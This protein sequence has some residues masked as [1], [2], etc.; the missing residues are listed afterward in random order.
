LTAYLF[1]IGAGETA[2]IK[3]HQPGQLSGYRERHQAALLQCFAQHPAAFNP[4]F[5]RCFKARA[6][7]GEDFQ[8]KKMQLVE[9]HSS[10]FFSDA[11]MLRFAA[12]T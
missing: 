9:F 10:R 1:G 2:I 12:D 7:T 3:C 6:E 11:S 8:F 5:H 4:G